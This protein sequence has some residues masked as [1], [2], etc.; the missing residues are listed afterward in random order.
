MVTYLLVALGGAIGSVMRFWIASLML[1]R[2]GAAFPWGTLL[3]N[4]T[5]SF[6]IGLFYG[7]MVQPDGAPLAPVNTRAFF[8]V[9]ICG[10]YTTFSAFSLETFNL[11][12]SGEWFRAGAY[13]VAS[14]ALCLVAVWLGQLAGVMAKSARGS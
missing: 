1:A 14:V 2:V 7:I 6:L 12:R 11:A 13:C 9:G 3:I 8:M 10:G 4:I 5:G